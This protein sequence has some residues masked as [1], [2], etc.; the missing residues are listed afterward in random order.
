MTRSKAPALR[1]RG[2]H[3]F[4]RER[5]REVAILKDVSFELEAGRFLS[6]RFARTTDT[7]RSAPAQRTLPP[8]AFGSPDPSAGATTVPQG[9]VLLDLLPP[10][11]A[12]DGAEAPAV[13]VRV[14]AAPDR[15]LTADLPRPLLQR[16]VMGRDVDLVPERPLAAFTPARQVLGDARTMMVLQAPDET[17]SPWDGAPRPRPGEEDAARLARAL[18]LWW[19]D[20]PAGEGAVA[21]VGTSAASPARWSAAT[22]LDGS[23]ALVEDGEI[24]PWALIIA[25]RI[26]FYR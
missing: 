23:V 4:Q 2:L 26:V 18:T 16:L 5:T 25:W 12:D 13:R 19:G 17:A 7:L 9:I 15:Q 6:Y 8:R 3:K 11:A 21:V 1:V 10:E 24:A 14:R 20:D 22:T